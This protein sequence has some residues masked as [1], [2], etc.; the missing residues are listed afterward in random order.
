[1]FAFVSIQSKSFEVKS[2]GF[3]L[4]KVW[5]YELLPVNIKQRS[6]QQPTISA[7]ELFFLVFKNDEHFQRKVYLSYNLGQKV[8]DKFMKLS[9]TSFSMKCF[10]ADIL[11]FFTE[12]C[13]N[14]AFWWLATCHQI[15]AFQGFLEI[16]WFPKNLSLKLLG[17]LWGNLYFYFLVRVTG[18]YWETFWGHCFLKYH[19][20]K[21]LL[22][23][24][25]MVAWG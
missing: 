8:W 11:W 14:L 24:D 19:F 25:T 22:L 4:L 9:K 16:P 17:N 23:T 12:K 15:Q 3:C 5:I 21:T 13:Q 18:L 20:K 2:S 10:T 7:H 6:V 1:M